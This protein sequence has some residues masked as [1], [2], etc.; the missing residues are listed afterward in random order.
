MN[1]KIAVI[2]CGQ[3][4]C[5]MFFLKLMERLKE[6]AERD[7]IHLIV[8]T[9]WSCDAEANRQILDMMQLNYVR[10]IAIDSPGIAPVP[11]SYYHQMRQLYY[12]LR[13]VPQDYIVFK[14]RPDIHVSVEAIP[15]V[16]AHIAEAMPS[17]TMPKIFERR[18]WVPQFDAITPFNVNDLVFAGLRN[19]IMKLVNFDIS[20]EVNNYFYDR[21]GAIAPPTA[22]PSL[23]E[24]RRYAHIF[25]NYFPIIEEIM[26][27][28]PL[29]Y[30]GQN[31]R[32]NVIKYNY[33]SSIYWEHISVYLFL[34]YSYF[35]VGS[36]AYSGIIHLIRSEKLTDSGSLSLCG[37]N[38]YNN[39]V[40][41][42]V[43]IKNYHTIDALGHLYC[44]KHDWLENIFSGVMPDESAKTFILDR[45]HNA[46]VVGQSAERQSAFEEYIR[47]LVTVAGFREQRNKKPT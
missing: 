28:S 33:A 18:V 23:Q 31:N 22:P 43:F 29:S 11:H 3:I 32:L 21:A 2:L 42:S 25:M 16:A 35:L 37:V 45:V 27:V 1:N 26:E 34:M 20:F 12:A 6:L 14:M 36:A 19:D 10:I 7:I 24:N 9:T 47:G 41:A 15:A 13:N 38:Y 4:R 8:I 39:M 46:L 30:G 5:P 17:P 40:D 44:V